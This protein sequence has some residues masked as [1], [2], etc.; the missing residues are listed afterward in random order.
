MNLE[1]TWYM[2]VAAILFSVG[3]YP[4]LARRNMIQ[5]LIGIEILTAAANLNF[6][7]MGKGVQA[8]GSVDPLA[9]SVVM[10]SILLG[11]C[12]ATVALLLIINA[13]RHYRSVDVK[14]L[15]RLRW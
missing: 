5:I 9:E 11:A 14:D 12:V 1:P 8:D 3:L 15:R 13:Y 4:L 7:A 10:I 2:V 6:L